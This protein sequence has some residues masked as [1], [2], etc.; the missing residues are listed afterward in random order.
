MTF[1]QNKLPIFESYFQSIV[2]QINAM[3]LYFMPD[4]IIQPYCD[5]KIDKDNGEM[6]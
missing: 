5:D 3:Q 2:Q 4:Q 1:V 6:I